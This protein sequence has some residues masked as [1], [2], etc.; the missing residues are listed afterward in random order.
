[1]VVLLEGMS[2]LEIT[3]QASAFTDHSLKPNFGAQI[4]QSHPPFSSLAHRIYIPSVC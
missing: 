4:K 3:F 2:V 1:M